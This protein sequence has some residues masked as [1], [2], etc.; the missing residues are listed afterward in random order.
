[1][2]GEVVHANNTSRGVS[3]GEDKVPVSLNGGWN[4]L[5]LK[6]TQ[7]TGDWA[8]CVRLGDS[9]GGIPAGIRSAMQQGAVKKAAPLEATKGYLM[10]W[11][12]SA[13]YSFEDRGPRGLFDCV[14]P[15]EAAFAPAGDDAPQVHG[16]LVPWV[17]LPREAEGP[18]PCRWQLL[19]N[20][21]MEVR[22]GGIVSKRK[23]RDHKIHVEFRLPFMPKAREQAR[24]NS[25][26][27]VQGRYEIQILDSY[28]MPPK[29]N[30][31]G[32]IYKV[33]GPRVNMCA[34]PLQWQTYDITFRAARFDGTGKKTENAR[35]SVM[36]NGVPIHE[37]LVLPGPTAGC[38][39][40]NE[41]EPGGLYLQDHGNPVWFRNIW[42]LEMDKDRG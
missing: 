5:M 10:A 39:D 27:Y 23:F 29:D 26:V 31:C 4:E 9:Q 41:S 24:G 20:S 40:T 36:H 35:I 22:G 3:P 16:E 6:V 13:P 15:P 1:M 25:G 14:F 32:G 42:V 8:A 28:G 2:N 30:E 12:L 34:P 19:D 7:G 37:D 21:A 17:P 11:E 33:S 38:L 18:Q